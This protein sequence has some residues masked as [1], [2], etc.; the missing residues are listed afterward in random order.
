MLNRIVFAIKML[1]AIN[2]ISS[3]EYL[4]EWKQPMALSEVAARTMIDLDWDEEEGAAAAAA[5]SFLM[6]FNV[7]DLSSLVV[8]GFQSFVTTVLPFGPWLLPFLSL[9]VGLFYVLGFRP[10]ERLD[11]LS[12]ISR[13]MAAMLILLVSFSA[14]W[15]APTWMIGASVVT[16]LLGTG[17]EWVKWTMHGLVYLLYWWACVE[18]YLA[19]VLDLPTLAY[20]VICW[21]SGNA[22]LSFLDLYFPWSWL[23]IGK[24]AWNSLTFS[25]VVG[26][27]NVL[28]SAWKAVVPVYTDIANDVQAACSFFCSESDRAMSYLRA[29]QVR[30]IERL[31]GLS[32]IPRCKAIVTILVAFCIA[33][34]WVITASITA[35]LIGTRIDWTYW[36][37]HRLV[38]LLFGWELYMQVFVFEELDMTILF[39]LVACW[40]VG[41]V[42]VSV[43]DLCLPILT[44]PLAVSLQ[45]VWWA[46]RNAMV[47]NLH[48]VALMWLQLD[49]VAI[50]NGAVAGAADIANDV[51][52][53][54][55]NGSARAV[56]Y[57]REVQVSATIMVSLF[58]ASV[59]CLSLD[60]CVYI[61]LNTW[62][63]PAT[64]QIPTAVNFA[65]VPITANVIG[66][67]KMVDTA[68]EYASSVARDFT[69]NMDPELAQDV[70]AVARNTG[71]FVGAIAD[72]LK[73][74]F[75]E[76]F[77]PNLHAALAADA[78]QA[79][80][81]LMNTR[82][83]APN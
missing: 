16:L 20:L 26:I 44:F 78:G 18:A 50:Y 81:A 25:L 55:H 28:A 72:K 52:S 24:W 33:P 19:G 21:S 10:V 65:P 4:D 15:M 77:D 30:L 49:V 5:P 35:L 75:P 68:A 32:F 47:F 11:G 34:N 2:S 23:C 17:W 9:L 31:D 45:L 67:G 39:I 64:I 59:A 37:M 56:S 73:A 79:F 57:L 58:V 74:D 42:I 1:K 54:L 53:F 62:N 48:V 40:A 8:D 41:R 70:Q 43:L 12:G 80:G 27:R 51:C 13:C 38:D 66:E 14:G 83:F 76:L 36:T 7:D 69:R 82:P 46:F 22:L 6:S 60:Y 63:N 3:N 29:E 71:I 61:Q